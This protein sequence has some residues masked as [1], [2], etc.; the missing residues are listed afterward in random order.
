MP[1]LT[2]EVPILPGTG[3]VEVDMLMSW[4]VLPWPERSLVL[5]VAQLVV[6]PSSGQ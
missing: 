6:L 5:P 3:E 2:L 4:P 1:R